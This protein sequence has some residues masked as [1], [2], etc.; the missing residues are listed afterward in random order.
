MHTYGSKDIVKDMSKKDSSRSSLSLLL[1]VFTVIIVITA[2]CFVAFWLLLKQENH[3]RYA[4][5]KN[6]AAEKISKTAWGME[7]NAENVFDEVGKHLLSRS[8]D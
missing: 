4:A 5:I 6:V 1:T 8:R 7:M 3:L 2:I